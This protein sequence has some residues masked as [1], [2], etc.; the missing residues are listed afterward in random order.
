MRKIV[1]VYGLIAGTILAGM[2]FL[3]IAVV[4]DSSD[5]EKGQSLGYISRALGFSMIFFG[6]RSHRDK[7]LHGV[8]TFNLAFRTG[9]LITLIASVLYSIAWLINLNYVDT[10][11]IER[12]TDYF[13]QQI[14]LSGKS[15]SDIK[16][17][18]E[19]FH[20]NMK[21]YSNPA[22][23]ALF[24]F[25]EVFPMGLI[26]TILCSMLMKKSLPSPPL[27]NESK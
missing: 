16:L 6:I 11:F 27:S 5:F 10:N 17:E 21:N 23:M 2:V 1:I 19:A 7:N 26:I 3:M 8:I 12:Y 22:V 20:E 15:E 25:L 4:G 9:I 18:L 24:T 13:A 14:Q